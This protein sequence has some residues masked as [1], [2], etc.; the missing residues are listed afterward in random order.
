MDSCLLGCYWLPRWVDSGLAALRR[1][2]P[3]LPGFRTEDNEFKIRRRCAKFVD[4]IHT[5][6][7]TLGTGEKLGHADFYVNRGP[8]QQPGCGAEVPE[9]GVPLPIPLIGDTCSHSRAYFYYAESIVFPKAFLSR[10]CSSYPR[11][12]MGLCNSNLLAY[13]GEDVSHKARGSY[14]L[15]TADGRK[16]P[17][18]KD[19]HGAVLRRC[20]ATDPEAFS[21]DGKILFCKLCEKEIPVKKMF[22]CEQH[23]A[24][25]MHKKKVEKNNEKKKQGENGK[26]QVLIVPVVSKSNQQ[27]EFHSRVCQAFLKANIPLY[28]LEHESIRKLFHDYC[29]K[30]LPHEWTLRKKFVRAFR[31]KHPELA[32]PPEPILTRWGTWVLASLYY[33]D[34]L[35]AVKE[36][37][38]MFDESDSQYI[39]KAKKSMASTETKAQLTFIKAYMDSIPQ[40]ISKLEYSEKELIQVVDE[41]KK[42][43]DRATSWPGSIGTSVRNKLE[44]VLSRNPAWKTIIDISR[45]LKGE[46][47]ETPLSYTA[48]ELSNFKYLPL[49]SVDVERS[50]S[51]MK[52]LLTDLRHSFKTENLEKHLIV[53]VNG[54]DD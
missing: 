37:V 39:A 47:P 9:F 14:Y 25:A 7:V 44:Y 8:I 19:C 36:V 24:T 42:F 40:L 16:M 28:K 29:S 38:N 6:F 32:L 48:N 15:K 46:T 18:V 43:E 50:F 21:T 27:D 34:N 30:D 45:S 10:K 1:L 26:K 49:V 22:Q 11:F 3:A 4:I 23:K 31:E 13:M 12:A 5:T 52:Q 51:R 20:V 17:K 41:M 35:E 2:D 54:F 53:Q 33:A